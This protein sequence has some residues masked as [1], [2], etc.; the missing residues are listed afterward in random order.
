ASS[1]VW[2]PGMVRGGP[3]GAPTRI[4]LPPIANDT[5][6][7]AAQSA[8]GP[9]STEGVIAQ[10]TTFGA[11]VREAASGSQ[12]G[13][14][15]WRDGETTTT[16]APAPSSSHRPRSSVPTVMLRFDAW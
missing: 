9:V 7:V 16:S 5:I 1:Q 2:R 14:G 10:T 6:G 12:P 11:H 3:S 8:L 13:T 4:M 15:A